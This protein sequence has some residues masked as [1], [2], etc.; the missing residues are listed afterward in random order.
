[1]IENA[2]SG[3]PVIQKKIEQK[4]MFSALDYASEEDED[5]FEKRMQKTLD[6]QE[7]VVNKLWENANKEPLE[8]IDL[9]KKTKGKK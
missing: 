2:S 6:I 1:M 4:D 9:P 8:E 5:D 7:K 3:Q